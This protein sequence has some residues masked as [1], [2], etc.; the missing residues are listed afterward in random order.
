MSNEQPKLVVI[1]GSTPGVGTTT[2]ANYVAT[3][4]ARRG[5]LTLLIE[6]STKTGQSV[7]MQKG[8]HEIHKSLYEVM[9]IPEKLNDN[10]IRSA[11][12]SKLFYLCMNFRDDSLKMSKYQPFN[13][14]SVISEAKKYFDY[15]I[16]DLPS[17]G[18]EPAVATVYSSEFIHKIDHNLVVVN[19]KASSYKYLN[20]F[21][22]ILELAR[23]TKPRATTFILN[24][25]EA[26][27]YQD[28]IL[29]YLKSLPITKPVNTM[30]LPY[31]EGLTVVCNSGSIYATGVNPKTK[32]YFKQIDGIADIIEKDLISMTGAYTDEEGEKKKGFLAS[33]FSAKDKPKDKPKKNKKRISQGPEES[34]DLEYEEELLEEEQEAKKKPKKKPKKEKKQKPPKLPKISRKRKDEEEA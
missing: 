21:N 19:E 27:H 29:E 28:Y 2:V 18:R 23:E 16:L 14:S 11:H 5:Y 7:Y 31:I 15:I 25:I 12:C 6:F 20:D 24:A 17:D 1:T 32:L 26:S 33:L 22:S 30:Y 10:T 3:E 8:L 9:T 13:I 34:E 4:I